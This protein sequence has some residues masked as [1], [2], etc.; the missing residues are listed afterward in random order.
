MITLS[1]SWHFCLSTIPV[2]LL[3]APACGLPP[4]PSWVVVPQNSRAAAAV[5]GIRTPSLESQDG[6]QY[7]L[8]LHL[9]DQQSRGLQTAKVRHDSY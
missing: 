1:K 9:T 3:L 6:L 7:A 5:L 4:L 2:F 8:L